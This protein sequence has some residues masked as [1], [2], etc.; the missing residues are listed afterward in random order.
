[1]NSVGALKVLHSSRAITVAIFLMAFVAHVASLPRT[2]DNVYDEG[3]IVFGAQRVL[4][5]DIPYRDFWTLYAPGQFYAV[6]GLFKLFGSSV[7][8]ERLWDA[9]VRAGVVATASARHVCLGRVCMR[10]R[11]LVLF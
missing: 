7:L 9:A 4:E 6:A 5:G 11:R 8:V 10:M 3:L 1:M 2:I